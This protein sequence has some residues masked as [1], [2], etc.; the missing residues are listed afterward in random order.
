MTILKQALFSI[1]FAILLFA[2]AK[3]VVWAVIQ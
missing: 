1:A 3:V 2:V